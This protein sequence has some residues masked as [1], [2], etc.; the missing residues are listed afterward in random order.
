MCKFL[1]V[2]AFRKK[3]VSP[4]L[5]VKEAGSLGLYPCSGTVWDHTGGVTPEM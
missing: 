2:A 1:T 5:N 4:I 3:W